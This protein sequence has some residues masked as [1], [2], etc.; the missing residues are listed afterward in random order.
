[1]VERTSPSRSE[2]DQ[3]DK[4][5][6]CIDPPTEPRRLPCRHVFCTKCL[7]GLLDKVPPPFGKLACP[8]CRGET[9]PLASAEHY[10]IDDVA[11]KLGEQRAFREKREEGTKRPCKSCE[12]ED[13]ADATPTA[14][15]RECGGGI[16]EECVQQH[17]KMKVFKKHKCVSW[18]DFSAE[19]LRP[20]N[21]Q[22]VCAVHDL[23]IQ[24]FC[25]KCDHFICSLCLKERHKEHLESAKSLEEVSQKRLAEVR[26]VQGE[27]EKRL[28]ACTR[29]LKDLREM[30]SGL[31]DYPDSLVR[32]IS[33]T[34]D[35]YMR[36]LRVWHDQKIS[37]ACEI[38]SMMVKGITS[39]KEDM[40]N[41]LAKL[42]TGIQTA[43]KATICTESEDI[44]EM[45]GRAIQLLRTTLEACD[46]S[47]VKRPLVFEKADIRFGKLREIEDGDIRVEPP[48]F[49]FMDTQ[50]EIR[51]SF[52]LPVHTKPI[53]KVLY[54][55]QKQRSVT[56]YPVDHVVDN[57]TVNF[58]PRV[59]GRHTIEVWVGGVRCKRCDDAMVVHGV[60]IAGSV[61]KPGPDWSGANNIHKGIV[62]SSEQLPVAA[63]FQLD[64]VDGQ[65]EN[66]L[67][68]VQVQWDSEEVVKYQWGSDDKYEFE[69]VDKCQIEQ[70]DERPM[71]RAQQLRTADEPMRRG[72]Q[73]MRADEPADEPMMRGGPY[74]TD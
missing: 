57:C 4:C 14:Y 46:I 37:E 41:T 72:E 66:E 56:L 61:V 10:P 43:T 73:L 53:V 13:T 15:C 18:K 68:E 45:S 27:A 9:A 64:Q 42:S 28:N 69:L 44:I 65:D 19:T 32:S 74:Y 36:K 23:D 35:E 50:N 52:T 55:S 70:V 8:N 34:F 49:C 60:P 39:Q 16:C 47:P 22:R 25:E 5:S 11:Q 26:V 31:A 63:G 17:K 7:Q 58:T 48:Q 30:E 24:L 29:L 71:R 62:M 40:E 33:D 67:F 6:L 21:A 3:E 2:P 38:Y 59:A 1:M 51:V 12:D 54:G 20:S